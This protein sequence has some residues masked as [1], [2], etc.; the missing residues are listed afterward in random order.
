MPEVLL[1]HAIT[2]LLVLFRTAG[3]LAFAPL[4]GGKLLPMSART[5]MVVTLSA[6]VYPAVS[7]ALPV[8]PRLDL[9]SL[10]PLMVSEL[11]IGTVVGLIASIPVIS[12]QLGGMMMG[13]QM[14]LGMVRAYD[15]TLEMQTDVLSTML[16]YVAMAVFVSMGGLEILYGAMVDSF[17]TIPLGGL[18]PGDTPLDLLLGVIQS[19][20]VL[21]YRV[22]MPV[23]CIIVLQML[24]MAFVMKT[25][26]QINILSV[27]FAV[28]II[29][30]VVVL[31]ASL[32]VIK[33]VIGDEIESVLGQVI[34][35]VWSMP[36]G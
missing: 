30:G 19:G 18:S 12:L 24:A 21:A 14:G 7:V 25:M 11:L 29:C 28:K 17:V 13:Y 15:P 27:G 4:I 31:M 10:G 26:P 1:A 3:M 22:A 34:G 33:Q 20:Y 6:A 8:P 5:L 32:G 35:W 23:L 2:W 36:A 9:L 16:F